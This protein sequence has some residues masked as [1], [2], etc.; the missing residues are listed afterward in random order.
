MLRFN[1]KYKNQ[2][3]PNK[4]MNINREDNILNILY[5]WITMWLSKNSVRSVCD[6]KNLQF[7]LAY[8]N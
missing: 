6:R 7:K 1:F 4:I 8:E 2:T 5:N 3:V